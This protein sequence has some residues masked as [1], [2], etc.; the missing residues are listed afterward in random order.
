MCYPGLDP[1]LTCD[2]TIHETPAPVLPD[3]LGE[4]TSA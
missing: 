4:A 1:S 2:T 3:P